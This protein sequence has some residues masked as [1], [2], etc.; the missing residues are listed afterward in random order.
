MNE[1]SFVVV[2]RALVDLLKKTQKKRDYF[3]GRLIKSEDLRLP[4]QH[5]IAAAI[6]NV[7]RY[8]I[9]IYEIEGELEMIREAFGMEENTDQ[10]VEWS[11]EEEENKEYD[12]R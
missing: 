11:G 9:D 12:A 7:N 5:M 8:D 3:R 1:K 10:E 2:E 4:K 6:E